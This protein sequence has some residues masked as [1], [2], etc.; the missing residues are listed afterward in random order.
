MSKIQH[1]FARRPGYDKIG[2]DERLTAVSTE[3]G[4][5]GVTYN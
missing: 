1:G 5:A 2:T 3:V 4:E